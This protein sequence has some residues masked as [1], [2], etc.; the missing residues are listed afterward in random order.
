MTIDISKLNRSELADLRG[1]FSTV[2]G[3]YNGGR[4]TTAAIMSMVKLR[5][6]RQQTSTANAAFVAAMIQKATVS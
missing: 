4:Q 6:L 3:P 5:H 2:F 1:I